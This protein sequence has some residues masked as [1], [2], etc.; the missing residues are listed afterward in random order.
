MKTIMSEKRR[1]IRRA[2]NLPLRHRDFKRGGTVAAKSSTTNI[3]EG[4][5][6]FKSREFV[7]LS[8]RLVLEISL[9][10]AIEPVKV[11]SRVIWIKK[12]PSSKQYEI[13]SRFLEMAKEDRARVTDFINN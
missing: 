12:N 11:I 4:G 9:P 6:S 7:S 8:C 10:A 3:S 1:Y 13:G 2:Y 5:L